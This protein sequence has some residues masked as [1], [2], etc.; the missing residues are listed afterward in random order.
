M[1]KY[2]VRM[3]CMLLVTL[4]FAMPASTTLIDRGNGLIYNGELDI[5][6]LWDANYAQSSGFDGDGKM[7]W[8]ASVSFAD[9]LVP[10]AMMTGVYPK[11]YN[12]TLAVAARKQM[13]L[14]A[15]VA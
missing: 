15:M 11:A 6:W 4:S 14:L 10:W 5:T 13:N 1:N 9:N 8:G 2:L 3:I 12:Q 7:S